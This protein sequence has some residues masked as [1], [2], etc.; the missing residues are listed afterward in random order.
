LQ[1]LTQVIIAD[2]T[3]LKWRGL[4]S[5]LT[6][7]PFII[8]AFVGANISS[9]VLEHI[10]WRWGCKCYSSSSPH[11]SI[12]VLPTDGMFAILIPVS[13]SPLIITLYWAERKAKR[14]GLIN[15][16]L[17]GQDASRPLTTQIWA[18]VQALDLIGLILLGASVA[19]ILLPLTLSQTVHK[20][21]DNPSIIVMIVIGVVLLFVFA[22]WDIKFASRPIMPGR[23]LKNKAFIGAVWIGFFDFVAFYLTNTYLFSFALV[24]KPWL[25][26]CLFIYLL[27]H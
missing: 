14:L 10:G 25:A 4:V 9:A 18:F 7:S 24:V 17:I 1:L 2:I 23:F 26:T 13:L 21:W 8:N 3:T 12:Q 16:N 11:Q 19:L 22:F 5:S 27:L 6:S 15:K 20:G